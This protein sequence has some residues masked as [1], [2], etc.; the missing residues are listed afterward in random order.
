MRLELIFVIISHSILLPR[1]RSFGRFSAENVRGS[2]PPS[3]RP[4]SAK[5]QRVK[6]P[7]IRI[8]LRSKRVPGTREDGF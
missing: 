7:D 2:L 8:E 1:L 6:I 4:I 5:P 3:F